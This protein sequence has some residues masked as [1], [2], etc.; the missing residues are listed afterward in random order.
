[1]VEIDK[2]FRNRQSEAKSAELSVHRR[3]SL[4]KW[5][6]QRSQPLWFN[7]NPCVGNFEMKTCI[8]VVK[9]AN[10]DLSAFRREF[11]CV[12]YQVPEHLL[13]PNQI[14]ENLIF[15]R[16]NSIK[17]FNCFAAMAEC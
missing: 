8:F 11:H 17:T 16:L 9:R 4:L 15:F 1:M 5:L 6:K 2:T 13:K 12:V 3:I 14:T 7:S 10:G